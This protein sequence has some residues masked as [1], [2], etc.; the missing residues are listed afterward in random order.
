MPNN[1]QNQQEEFFPVYLFTGFLEAG[2][3]RFMQSAMED[4]RFSTGERTLVLICE[5]GEEEYDLKRIPQDN[6][7]L[8]VVHDAFDINPDT[9][10]QLREQYKADRVMIEYNGMW[11]LRDLYENLPDDW[12]VYQEV[13]IAD[14]STFLTY[15]ANMRSLVVDKLQNCELVYFNRYEDSMGIEQFHQIV[16]G[17]SRRADIYYEFPDGKTMFDDIEDPLPFDTEADHIT[18]EDQDFA[19]WFRDLMETPKKYKDKTMTFKA[20][21]VKNPSFP[22]NVFAVGRHIMTCCVEDIQYCWIAAEYEKPFQPHKK[23]WITVTGKI[24]LKNNPMQ[25]QS[26]P[27]IRVTELH[28]AEPPAQEVATFY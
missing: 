21:A 13:F 16:R 1:Q 9:L 26:V 24:G 23:H 3:T 10:S 28:D 8:H 14:A 20:L 22:K 27:V 12:A 15:N 17:V 18:I 2:K 6:V 5:E 11:Q 25:G 7:F 4:E 19:L